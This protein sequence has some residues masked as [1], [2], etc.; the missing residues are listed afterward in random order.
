MKLAAHRI[1][2]PDQQ[3][4]PLLLIV[5]ANAHYC[6]MVDTVVEYASSIRAFRIKGNL[7]SFRANTININKNTG[8]FDFYYNGELTACIDAGSFIYRMRE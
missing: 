6:K 1:S 7:K 3:K 2:G 5:H 8:K 4:P